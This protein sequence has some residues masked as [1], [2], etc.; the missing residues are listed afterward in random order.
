MRMIFFSATAAASPIA[1]KSPSDHAARARLP[2]VLEGQRLK[3]WRCAW[4]LR[5]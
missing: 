3:S 1:F 5:P 4:Q 2:D